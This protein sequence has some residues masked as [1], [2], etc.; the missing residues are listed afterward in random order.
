[1]A[2]QDNSNV[3]PFEP[4]YIDERQM[5][6]AQVMRGLDADPQQAAESERIG[7]AIN[8]PGSVVN[9]DPDNY[10]RQLRSKLV[11]DFLDNNEYLREYVRQYPLGAQISS[12]DWGQLD[13]VSQLMQ[14]FTTIRPRMFSHMLGATGQLALSSIGDVAEGIAEQLLGPRSIAGTAMKGFAEGY[15][16]QPFAPLDTFQADSMVKFRTDHPQV[17][18]ALNKFLGGSEGAG[19]K[20][21]A[22]PAMAGEIGLRAFSGIVNAAGRVAEKAA[23]DFG[24]N[25][26][27]AID[28][29]NEARALFGEYLPF[30]GASISP[31]ISLEGIKPKDLSPEML[32]WARD[33]R[34]PANRSNNTTITI[35][36]RDVAERMKQFDELYKEWHGSDTAEISSE[37][38]SNF[39]QVHFGRSTLSVSADKIRE[40]YGDTPPT[41]DDNKLGWL[42]SAEE[43]INAALETGRD[44][45]IPWKDVGRITPETMEVI[46]DGIR[47]EHDGFTVDEAKEAKLP[48]AKAEEQPEVSGKAEPEGEKP[49]PQPVGPTGPHIMLRKAAG[50]EPEYHET[51]GRIPAQEGQG[52]RSWLFGGGKEKHTPI[53]LPEGESQT[54][55]TGMEFA[56]VNEGKSIS[57]FK[58]KDLYPKLNFND[59]PADAKLFSEF[60]GKRLLEL[61]G[62][63]PVHIIDKKTLNTMFPRTKGRDIAG[64]HFNNQIFLTKET[65]AAE[66]WWASQVALHEAGHAISV[67]ALAR[68]PKLMAMIGDLMNAVEFHYLDPTKPGGGKKTGPLKDFRYAFDHPPGVRER[69]FFA[70]AVSNPGFRRVLMDTPVSKELLRRHGLDIKG[71]SIWEAVREILKDLWTSIRGKVPE[72]SVMDAFLRINEHLEEATKELRKARGLTPPEALFSEGKKVEPPPELAKSP[73]AKGAMTVMR[74]KLLEATLR[75]IK[76]RQDRDV[77]EQRDFEQVQEAKR[78]TKA[79]VDNEPRVREEVRQDLLKRRDIAADRFLRTGQLPNGERPVRE[80]VKFDPNVIDPEMKGKIPEEF[81]GEGGI[82]PDQLAST[83]GHQTGKELLEDLARLKQER[84]DAG[85]TPARHLSNLVDVETQRRMTKD[86]GITP[87]E[88]IDRAER[89]ITNPTEEDLLHVELEALAGNKISKEDIAKRALLIFN[90]VP[91]DTHDYLKYVNAMGREGQRVEEAIAEGR[92]QDALMAKQHQQM[93][94][95]QA[96]FT[97]DLEKTRKEFTGIAG[98]YSRRIPPG[99]QKHGVAIQNILMRVMDS[100]FVKRSAED[101]ARQ[102]ELISPEQS[103]RDWVAAQNHIA[104]IYDDPDNMPMGQTLRVADYLLDPEFSKDWHEMTPPE[105][106]ELTGSLKSL[107]KD[108]RADQEVVVK[109]QKRNLREV[110]SG[111]IERLKASVDGKK[112]D[113]DRDSATRAIG[114]LLLTPETW[115]RRLDLLDPRGA[116]TQTIVR[117]ILEGQYSRAAM[118]K[119]YAAKLKEIGDFGDTREAISND[120]FMDPLTNFKEPMKLTKGH[121][122]SIL[123]NMG[124]AEQRRKL[125]VG[126]G[127][128]N[129]DKIWNWLF[130][131]QKIT[132]EDFT[133]AQ[134]LGKL[135]E[136]LFT[137]SERMYADLSDWAPE[138]IPLGKIDT[139]WGLKDEWYHPLIPDPVRHGGLRPQDMMEENGFHVTRPPAG[140]TKKRTGATYPLNLNFD[141]VPMR[142]KQMIND[143]NMRPAIVNT[144]KVVLDKDFRN[145]FT[146]YY[147]KEYTKQLTEW[148]KDS[149]GL[150]NFTSAKEGAVVN[151][152]Q[153]MRENMVTSLI[154]LNLATI[155]KHVP[156]AAIYSAGEV[157]T[158]K[159]LQNLQLAATMSPQYLAKAADA[160][161]MSEELQNRFRSIR[162]GVYAANQ[163]VF[164]STNWDY[165]YWKARDWAAYIGT[166]PIASFDLFFSKALWITKYEEEINKGLAKGLSMEEIKGDAIYDANTAVRRTHGSTLIA[167][168]PAIMRQHPIF[169]SLLPFYTFFNNSLQRL[170]ENAWRA[171][172]S[173]SGREL[174]EMTGFEKTTFDRGMKNLMPAVGGLLLYSVVPSLIEQ[175]VSPLPTNDDESW[176]WWGS[177]VLTRAPLA[178]IPGVRDLVAATEEGHD[179]SVGILGSAYRTF[180]QAIRDITQPFKGDE[181]NPDPA[182]YL[183]HFNSLMGAGTGLT[184]EQPAKIGQFIYNYSQGTENLDDIENWWDAWNVGSRIVRT[185]TAREH[186]R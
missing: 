88:I 42:P 179:P 14:A 137:K 118:E 144:S 18:D 29:G 9:L 71:N 7:Q 56:G 141:A 61:A 182:K 34:P 68:S 76:E 1:M 161:R 155:A 38:S 40:L 142:I 122:W 27:Q 54:L 84:D 99:S 107:Q 117:Q 113:P 67:E 35:Y 16:D 101:I 58:F 126:Y 109:T 152:L 119:E 130:N 173:L 116:F 146:L 6:N 60:W 112:T 171:K 154:G 145:A 134:N 156:T 39:G 96:K 139:P 23:R 12:Q 85:V 17:Y 49:P 53:E 66:P 180:P 184:F 148:L 11:N 41:A 79:W 74:E 166:Y 164:K 169:S 114:A 36:R 167:S 147:G 72:D 172:L 105:L 95:Y 26:N 133:R 174:P 52:L 33:G 124:N 63:L 183:R 136:E 160:M 159:F 158:G 178:M 186:K 135:F 115:F 13:K 64:I 75:H 46:R 24:Y 151:F 121:L 3:I 81:L 125:A 65:M 91:Q 21:L 78:A 149:A 162:E 87:G 177:K 129:P 83:F 10:K 15:G 57:S 92:W 20:G 106:R 80:R 32:A 181:W 110:V 43:Q 47:L 132:E 111:L 90:R 104:D 175:L 157:N 5:V 163:D 138:R 30:H 150:G 94:F 59:L 143:I 123:S 69:E 31:H 8:I 153:F 44:V 140:Y 165:N 55:N 48:E 128:D 97:K 170:Y 51:L 131:V 185:G 37:A 45:D 73:F 25:E 120:L 103:L 98:R 100:G 176:A 50:L 28:A 2:E 102:W 86:Y 22:L 89:Y 70:E 62:D 127:I 4:D 77:K 108:G 19:R 82:H 168:R 93:L